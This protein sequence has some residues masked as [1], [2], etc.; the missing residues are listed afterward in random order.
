MS[1]RGQSL[2]QYIRQCKQVL[3]PCRNEVHIQLETST[4]RLTKSVRISRNKEHGDIYVNISSTTASYKLS[5]FYK[6]SVPKN[7]Y[8]SATDCWT[9]TK[10]IIHVRVV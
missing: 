9:D 7:A 5:Q 4:R 10:V 6:E 1:H 3:L 2:T 8:I